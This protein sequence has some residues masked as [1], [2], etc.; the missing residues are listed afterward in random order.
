[1]N[2]RNLSAVLFIL[3]FTTAAAHARDLTASD[4]IYRVGDEAA[5]EAFQSSDQ[6]ESDAAQLW[7][8][9][10]TRYWNH[11]DQLRG[12]PIPLAQYL[13]GNMNYA[14]RAAQQA[15]AAGN[16]PAARFYD[17]SSRF[18]ND[19]YQQLANGQKPAIHF[20]KREMLNPI[21]GLPGTPWENMGRGDGNGDGDGARSQPS[22]Q[23]TDPI[24]RPNYH[25]LHGARYTETAMNE[26][27]AW[28]R[29]QKHMTREQQ[30]TSIQEAK[31]RN[32]QDE[33]DEQEWI[34]MTIGPLGG[35]RN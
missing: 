31:K 22:P 29:R 32:A 35:G 6:D 2:L 28:Y 14:R 7:R 15:A 4:L 5:K 17:A 25:W 30:D 27:I 18:W 12:R 21:P 16:M 19:I 10:A 20:P 11:A 1:M 8:Q 13:Q 34:K 24:P 23:V 3:V 33:R 26:L 9:W